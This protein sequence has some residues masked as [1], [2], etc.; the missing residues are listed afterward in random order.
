MDVHATSFASV[1]SY[2]AEIFR[3]FFSRLDHFYLVG[4]FSLLDFSIAVLAIDIIITAFF[5][6]FNVGVSS[7][8][9]TSTDDLGGKHTK[10]RVNFSGKARTGGR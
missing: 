8:D 7:S 3:M 1:L 9:V 6:T 2:L 5:V 10:R 4:S